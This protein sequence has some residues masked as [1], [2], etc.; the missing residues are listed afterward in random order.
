MVASSQANTKT[1]N[2]QSSSE[3]LNEWIRNLKSKKQFKR[4]TSRGQDLRSIAILQN[5]LL[6]NLK[7]LRQ[8]QRERSEKW[9]K[10]KKML[11]ENNN[12]EECDNLESDK[13][14]KRIE[15][16]EI[17]LSRKEEMK[18][19]FNEDLSDIDNFMNNLDSI[20]T[21]LVR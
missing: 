15:S 17:E 19:I 11:E 14:Q 2:I 1:L 5:S 4:R 12:N 3:A 16:L 7:T 21:A 10:I 8:R 6:S 9:H 20:K 13:D 18:K